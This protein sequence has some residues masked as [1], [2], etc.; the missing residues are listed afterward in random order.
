MS[1]ISEQLKKQLSMA[2]EEYK[3]DIQVALKDVANRMGKTG[4]NALIITGSLLISYLLY[5][6]IAGPTKKKK[7]EL[8]DGEE[9]A[10]SGSTY[11]M[12][13]RL[14]DQVLEQ[15]LVFLLNLAKERLIAYLTEI[16]EEHE[17][18]EPAAAE[19]QSA[20]EIPGSLN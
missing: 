12:L 2:T 9:G 16:S 19:E 15:T 14:A 11:N 6:G 1:E 18:T 13:D 7:K 20:G 10:E 5:R 4:M 3:E 8:E 17:D